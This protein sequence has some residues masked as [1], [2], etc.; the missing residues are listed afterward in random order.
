MARL[1]FYGQDKAETT[2]AK[3]GDPIV[4][5]PDGHEW[6]RKEVWPEWWQVDLP[7]E[8]VESWAQYCE[9]EYQEV[10]VPNGAPGETRQ[11]MTK[12]RRYNL[13]P[14]KLPTD[15]HKKLEGIGQGPYGQITLDAT[16]LIEA[17]KIK[18]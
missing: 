12:F 1:L 4:V 17:M 2:N 8:P 14:K 16:S 3:Q 18:S 15:L 9:A 11:V 13:D 6:G 5:R 10:P 7:G